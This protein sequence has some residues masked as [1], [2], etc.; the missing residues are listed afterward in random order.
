MVNLGGMLAGGAA[1]TIVIKAVDD[2]SST[3]NKASTGMNLLAGAAKLGV[4]AIAGAGIAIAAVGVSSLKAAGD[5]EQTQIAF[6]TMLGS[7]D[8]ANEVLGELADFAKKTPFTLTGIEGSSKQLLA[9][10]IETDSLMP[11]LKA[12]GDVS[13]GLSVP[14]ERL[15]LNFGQV[16]AQ[17]KLTGRELRDFAIAGVPLTA[18]LA[19]QLNVSEASISE[20]VSKGEIG[21]DKVEQAFI[22]M[23]SAGGKFENLMAK[24]ATTVQGKFSNLQDTFELI[25]RDIGA[26]FLPAIAN[27]ADVFLEDLLPAIQP[28]IPIIG[29]FLASAITSLTPIIMRLV[30]LL[31]RFIEFTTLLFDAL[32]PL[33]EPLSEITFE[34]LDVLIDV[35]FE[36]LPSIQALIPPI[37]KLLQALVPLIPPLGE[38]LVMFAEMITNQIPYLIP[39]INGLVKA[40]TWFFDKVAAGIDFVKTLVG[41]IKSLV[42]ILQKAMSGVSNFVGGALSGVFGGKSKSVNDA[43][44][45]PN[46]EIITTHPDDYL[47]ATKTPETLGGSSGRS[48]Y[49][50]IENIYGVDPSQISEALVNE[51]KNKISI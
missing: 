11:T 22:A 41:W 8:K 36:L 38:I 18:E 30:P 15:A 12:L 48:F 23:S 37:I 25:Q 4:A 21:F 16:K 39:L 40:L 26:A 42:D 47:I 51:L 29:E 34:L 24:Q 5:F 28:L 9:M 50:T 10:G 35:L 14:L 44:I 2:F 49:I 43:I 17:G 27:L 19:K 31:M 6:T 33:L 46:G 1:V 32:M 3:F 45:K 20:M 13:A 7:A